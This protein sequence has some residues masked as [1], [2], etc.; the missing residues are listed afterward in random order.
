[1]K[2]VDLAVTIAVVGW[3]ILAIVVARAMGIGRTDAER[4]EDD[5]EQLDSLRQSLDPLRKGGDL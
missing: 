2:S 5:A 3:I 1:M 4:D